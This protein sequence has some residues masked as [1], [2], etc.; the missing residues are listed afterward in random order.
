MSEAKH[1][2][3][4]LRWQQFGKEWCLTGQYGMR[5]IVLCVRKGALALRDS[6]HDL[7]IPFDPNH[8]DA[9]L[10]E[11]APDLLRE[12]DQLK[13]ELAQVKEKLS[14]ANKDLT[15][16]ECTNCGGSGWYANS[17]EGGIP[18][19]CHCWANYT[20]KL[21]AHI[22]TLRAHN[23]ALLE[24]LKLCDSAFICWQVG[25]IPGRPEDILALITKVRAAIALEKGEK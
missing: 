11:S 12:R 19:P 18:S 5:P 2:P 22:A 21:N 14:F 7:L 24:A 13:A 3:G 16:P 4:P 8:P 10:I 9:K 1:T 23:A 17:C 15:R 6:K 20:D 25:Q